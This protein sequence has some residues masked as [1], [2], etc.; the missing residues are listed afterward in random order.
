M[1]GMSDLVERVARAICD[2]DTPDGPSY[3]TLARA[4]VALVVE[5]CAKVAD[6]DAVHREGSL[7]ADA[8]RRV[9]A[10]I[11]ALAPAADTQTGKVEDDHA[12]T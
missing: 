2:A 9:A 8:S 1:D 11:R 3:E 4:A 5:E 7:Q 12:R 10:A 6:E